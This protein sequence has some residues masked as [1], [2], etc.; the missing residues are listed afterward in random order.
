MIYAVLD[1]FSPAKKM[2]ISED[3]KEFLSKTLNL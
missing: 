1:K 2:A 3:S